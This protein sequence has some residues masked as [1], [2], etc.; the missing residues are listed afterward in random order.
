LVEKV[1]EGAIKWV[2]S[3]LVSVKRSN[4]EEA[5][6]CSGQAI[7]LLKGGNIN[8]VLFIDPIAEANKNLESGDVKNAEELL[9]QSLVILK[10]LLH[11]IRKESKTVGPRHHFLGSDT[12]FCTACTKWTATPAN[13]CEHCGEEFTLLTCGKCGEQIPKGREY[14]PTCQSAA[15]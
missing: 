3:A 14:C 4:V 15:N 7:R 5:A 11:E 6:R 2:S 10:S 1:V 8:H 13:Y 12:I 9:E